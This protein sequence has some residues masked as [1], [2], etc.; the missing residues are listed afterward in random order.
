VAEMAAAEPHRLGVDQSA[1]APSR[2]DA[3]ADSG[4]WQTAH[5]PSCPAATL[6]AGQAGSDNGDEDQGEEAARERAGLAGAGP[7]LLVAPR[8]T[9]DN[10][11][12]RVEM[13]QVG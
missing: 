3:P 1:S 7:L 4:R 5:R 10:D 12:C 13:P 2:R 6:P 11:K 8:S 9:I